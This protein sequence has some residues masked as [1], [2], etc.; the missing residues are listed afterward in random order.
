[1]IA[2]YAQ[3]S[4]RQG[5][6][7]AVDGRRAPIDD[8]DFNSIHKKGAAL[9]FSRK[10]LLVGD[11]DVRFGQ[12]VVRLELPGNEVDAESRSPIVLVIDLADLR[13]GRGSATRRAIETV[14]AIG[15]ECDGSAIA[16]GLSAGE[17]MGRRSQMRMLICIGGATVVVLF[18]V[19]A[20]L[21]ARAASNSANA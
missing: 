12:G 17:R 9:N 1:M 8:A 18:V 4:G 11:V 16:A 13:D 21:L 14:R 2:A 19:A 20:R 5:L 7:A 3:A 10:P 6:E 15:R